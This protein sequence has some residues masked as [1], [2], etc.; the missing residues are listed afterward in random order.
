ML[1]HRKYVFGAFLLLIPEDG[2]LSVFLLYCS[3]AKN[4]LVAFPIPRAPRPPDPDHARL[5]FMVT[6]E[7]LERVLVSSLT[8]LPDAMPCRFYGDATFA[9][10]RYI[11]LENDGGTV[12]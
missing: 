9:S 12:R 2:G 11:A 5:N 1:R 3:R 8:C 10:N 7:T 4:I 6:H